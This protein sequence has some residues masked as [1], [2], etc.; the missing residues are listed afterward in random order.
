MNVEQE[1]QGGSESTLYQIKVKG[2]TYGPYPL[3]KVQE[4]AKK[5]VVS[6]I[7]QVSTD[8]GASWQP[9]SDFPEIFE[10]SSI[11]IGG[12]GGG[13]G[14][15]NI[16]GGNIGGGETGGGG[17]GGGGGGVGPT[18]QEV[19]YY[20]LNGERQG[21]TTLQQL[22]MMVHTGTL[23]RTDYACKE[24]AA[25]WSRLDMIPELVS[26]MGNKPTQ[27]DEKKTISKRVRNAFRESRPWTLCL[28]ILGLFYSGL[29]LLGGIWILA[30][31]SEFR[32]G[33]AVAIGCTNIVTAIIL[34][35]G[36]F[37]V[38]R[39]SNKVRRFDSESSEKRL[40]A[41]AE[42]LTGFWMYA[43]IIS[44]CYLIL[45]ITLIILMMA[46]TIAT[47]TF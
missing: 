33:A 29:G 42:S 26:I 6:R 15:G 18:E 20:L 3:T 5:S 37:L 13:F 34:G 9:A 14:G 10:A 1:N 31:G 19:W 8:N 47:T 41:V 40:V 11:G 4:L 39:H 17:G 12:G 21:P 16:G 46:G 43:S 27:D 32:S 38:I 35:T 7:N 44:I 22:Q 25:E 28:G 24:G 2:K 23:V 45:F 36:A 30:A